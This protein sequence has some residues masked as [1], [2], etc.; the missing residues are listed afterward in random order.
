M[1]THGAADCQACGSACDP[2]R[3][4]PGTVPRSTVS[5]GPGDVDDVATARIMELFYEHLRAGESKKQALRQAKLDYL[6]EASDEQR[7]PFYWAPFI[8]SGDWSPL[9]L[10]PP[11]APAWRAPAVIALLLALAA[12]FVWKRRHASA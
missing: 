1:V 4:L 2:I 10:P 3:R 5:A 9:D 6:S 11:A 7:D 8:L 12:L